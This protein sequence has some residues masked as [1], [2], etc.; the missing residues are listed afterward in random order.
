LLNSIFI[1]SLLI[2]GQTETGKFESADTINLGIYVVPS[3]VEIF[4]GEDIIPKSNYQVTVEGFINFF[5]TVECDSLTISYI[6]VSKLIPKV[7][8][9]QTLFG[10]QSVAPRDPALMESED[11]YIR[12]SGCVT[13]G[14]KID[15]ASDLTST[16]ELR[17][18]AYGQLPMGFEVNAVLSDEDL[19]FQPE[20]TSQELTELD[21]I[22]IELTSP[23]FS[24]SMGDIDIAIS[25]GDFLNFS[26][27]I[28]GAAAKADL[29]WINGQA[30]GSII[31]GEFTKFSFYATEGNQGPYPLQGKN[32]ERDIVIVAG[33]ENV[34]LNGEQ[35]KRGTEN[36]YIIDYNL[37]QLTFNPNTPVGVSDRI[38]VEYQYIANVYQ[39]SFYGGSANII[40][41]QDIT[42]DVGFITLADNGEEPIGEITDSIRAILESSGDNFPD[43]LV[44]PPMKQWSLVSGLTLNK[45][46]FSLTASHS[47]SGM[48]KN[49]YSSIDD[50]DNLGQAFSAAGTLSITNIVR[51]F[52][53]TRYMDSKFNSFQPIE[54][55]EEKRN[56]GVYS[57]EN[58]EDLIT[59]AGIRI[60]FGKLISTINFGYRKT[61]DETCQRERLRLLLDED[62]FDINAGMQ[63]I[64]FGDEQRLSS[65]LKLSREIGEITKLSFSGDMELYEG[66]S[67]SF[68]SLVYNFKPELGINVLGGNLG[69]SFQIE[70]KQARPEK[71]FKHLYSILSPG[72]G[73][74]GRSFSANWYRRM[75]RSYDTLAGNDLTTD[76]FQVSS[77]TNILGTK[78]SFNYSV[79][80]SQSE[81][82]EKKFEEVKIG[83][84][85]YSYDE[86]LDEYVP[87]PNGK[88][89]L[90]Y[91]PTG[92][93]D[94]VLRSNGRLTVAAEK[95]K[96]AL[97]S[98]FSITSSFEIENKDRSFS[99]ILP[100]PSTFESD[101]LSYG[102]LY[103]TIQ[104]NTLRRSK[105][106]VNSTYQNVR[107]TR[108][109][110]ISGDEI[111][112]ENEFR[113]SLAGVIYQSIFSELSGIYNIKSSTRPG[114]ENRLNSHNYSTELALSRKFLRFMQIG[115]N[116]ILT[117]SKGKS[118]T[119]DID[120]LI[121]RNTFVLQWRFKK[122]RT[123][124]RS[125]Q[126]NV[127]SNQEAL[128]YEI[129]GGWPNGF[130][131]SFSSSITYKFGSNIDLTL[132]G[133]G[134][135]KSEKDLDYDIELRARFLF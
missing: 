21:K 23:S 99:G 47:M 104:L 18:E 98:A 121:F 93:F 120:A 74:S 61:G 36:E 66:S 39:S 42:L 117:A 71:N 94:Q 86:E 30:F 59:S 84:G 81:I 91:E 12:T 97:G 134:T 83:T 79:S 40:G 129:S 88:Y 127:D 135:K 50:Q 44:S 119:T 118:G 87:D 131:Y 11:A 72:V 115:N 5:S 56:W 105:I 130:N 26:R 107:I 6:P 7:R 92:S 41:I 125:E 103:T 48:D 10:T 73:F 37:A 8:S 101:S 122:F 34:W 28:K 2:A 112:N 100:I 14:F 85:N 13:R 110:L 52:A 22:M 114:L 90:K 76:L 57:N 63:N 4:C 67:D 16:G 123:R 82:M 29:P 31:S 19:P 35:I 89:I 75:Y 53:S 116:I 102:N 17:I 54:T 3:S 65:D 1:I 25:A 80:G 70:E 20:G 58:Q 96:I 24:A 45:N 78:T 51:L 124:L 62:G 109:N 27:K 32:G 128:P 55:A 49:T 9:E 108:R 95:E 133:R 38:Y 46:N 64:R 111:Y 132:S 60:T 43:S 33:S 68:D 69:F 77:Y 106:N 15:E 126:I 113:L